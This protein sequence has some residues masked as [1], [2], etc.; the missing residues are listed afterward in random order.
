MTKTL[1]VLFCA[2]LAAPAAA[3][4]TVKSKAESGGFRGLGAYESSST[5]SIAGLKS[6][7]EG[8]MR[9]KGAVLGRMSG[10]KGRD[11]A[12]IT[13]VDLDKRWELDLKKK[14]YRESP[15]SLPPLDEEAEEAP[16]AARPGK[17]RKEKPTHRIK[18]AKVEVKKTGEKK[19]INGFPC[20]R[21]QGVATLVVEEI[22]TRKTSEFSVESEVWATP[23]TKDLKQAVKEEAA[24]AK[25]YLAKLGE[26]LG[27]QDRRRFALDS[28]QA[29]VKAGGPELEKSLAKLKRELDKIDGYAIVT[30]TVWKAPA[31]EPPKGKAP[32]DD[33]KDAG[34]ALSDVRGGSAGDIAAGFLGG[35]AKRAAKK[36][37]KQKARE[38]FAPKPGAPA[39][40]ARVE[41]LSVSVKAVSPDAFE[42]PKGFK[43]K[44]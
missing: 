38:A 14:T 18:S 44:G 1:A 8:S 24:F 32:K 3:D 16:K 42:I 20:A 7:D 29:L 4:V 21:H 2:A 25:A 5:R 36:K 26:K 39:L 28:A 15:V 13:R 34:S 12:V 43:K 10:K 6:R 31:S 40:S 41:V 19:A 11:S 23:W 35:L 9:F 27:A 17:G 30:E 22:A 33:D 37:A